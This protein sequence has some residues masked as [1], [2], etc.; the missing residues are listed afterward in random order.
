MSESMKVQYTDPRS[1]YEMYATIAFDVAK[2][3]V[4]ESG[5]PAEN[6]FLSATSGAT[7]TM[8][9]IPDIIEAALVANPFSPYACSKHPVVYGLVKYKPTGNSLVL[10]GNP[11]TLGFV[12]NVPIVILRNFSDTTPV[13]YL[14]PT[15]VDTGSMS[16]TSSIASLGILINYVA[17]QLQ[18][19][20]PFAGKFTMDNKTW[21]IKST[22]ERP[23]PPNV[24]A[25]VE[26]TVIKVT[27]TDPPNY[28][29]IK[30]Y[31][32][33]V[34]SMTN[35]PTFDPLIPSIHGNRKP[36]LV[37]NPGDTLNKPITTWGG[38]IDAGGGN[39]TVN[40]TY[41]VV[42]IS[43]DADT[44][45]LCNVSVLSNVDTVAM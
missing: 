3:R 8:R 9:E 24:D 19:P 45:M 2:Y 40:N 14:T 20:L 31:N 28:P 36:D 27:L 22:I 34:I 32:V 16:F 35:E 4:D 12:P 13:C 1:G 23:L 6:Y 25:N 7:E 21:G 5:V 11:Q 15:T 43:K 10:N 29:L 30:K 33:Y 37:L 41:F 44:D 39:V 26:S 38:G 17:V 42:A 18:I